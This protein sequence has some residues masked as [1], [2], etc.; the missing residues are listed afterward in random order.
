[1]H[2]PTVCR[3]AISPVKQASMVEAAKCMFLKLLEKRTMTRIARYYSRTKTIVPTTTRSISR[4]FRTKTP[5]GSPCS[6]TE[7]ATAKSCSRPETENEVLRSRSE[8]NSP[9]HVPLEH[10]TDGDFRDQLELSVLYFCTDLENGYDRGTHDRG[11]FSSI[12]IKSGMIRPVESE[13]PEKSIELNDEATCS[14]G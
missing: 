8:T 7:A 13:T 1:M 3:R 6:P 9:S 10:A 4:C 2:W 11:V 12:H 5:S 14:K